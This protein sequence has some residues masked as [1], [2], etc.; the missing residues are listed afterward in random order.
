MCVCVC[1]SGMLLAGV[2]LRN[3]PYVTDAVYIDQNWSAALR[4]VSLAVI[5]TRA[6]LGLNA[7]VCVCVFLALKWLK[8]TGLSML[9]R[10]IMFSLFK[11]VLT[12]TVKPGVFPPRRQL[13]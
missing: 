1:V 13:N 9:V 11:N 4:N 2:V 5:L 12:N 3:V 7:A 6:G 8:Y 10:S